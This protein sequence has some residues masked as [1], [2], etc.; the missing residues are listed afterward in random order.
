MY[1]PGYTTGDEDDTADYLDKRGKCDRCDC[2][3]THKRKHMGEMADMINDGFD[4]DD[5]GYWDEEVPRGYWK[6]RDGNLIKIADMTDK[7]LA[8]AIALFERN[9][10][11]DEVLHLVAEQERRADELRKAKEK[12]RERDPLYVAF[13]AGWKAGYRN[14]DMQC[15]PDVGFSMPESLESAW[16]NFKHGKKKTNSR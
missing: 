5:D 9:D 16:E 4:W 12:V 2:S 1:P 15:N 8:N 6:M 3:P 7:H 11:Y 13:K 14:C 10:R